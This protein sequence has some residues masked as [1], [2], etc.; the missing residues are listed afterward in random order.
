MTGEFRSKQ[1]CQNPCKNGDSIT[2]SKIDLTESDVENVVML[3]NV[4]RS[5]VD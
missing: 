3:N 5:D 1:T 2:M 4:N